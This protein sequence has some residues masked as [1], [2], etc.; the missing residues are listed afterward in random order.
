MVK[1]Q[2]GRGSD[3]AFPSASRCDF[4][5]SLPPSIVRLSVFVVL[6]VTAVSSP[7]LAQITTSA[8]VLQPGDAIAVRIPG[9]PKLSGEFAIDERGETVFPIIGTR[10]TAGL[11]WQTLRDSLMAAFGRELSTPD[12]ALSPLRRVYV[13]GSVDKPGIFFVHP[14]GTFAEVIAM[15]GGLTSDGDP[16]HI[17][18]VRDGASEVA[19]ISLDTA[20]SPSDLRSGDRIFVERR[21]W[22]DRNSA[23]VLSAG[24]GLLGVLV[25]VVLIR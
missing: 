10:R 1:L 12:L 15:A 22:F 9:E 5:H 8:L 14:L 20:M 25:T 19:R 17:R 18:I 24:A 11:P 4:A 21:G 13:L 6:C 3:S 16:T 2:T 7:A 23:V